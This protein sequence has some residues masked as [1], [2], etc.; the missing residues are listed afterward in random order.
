MSASVSHR[1]F[2]CLSVIALI[3]IPLLQPAL[4]QAQAT[5]P[6]APYYDPRYN[7][8]NMPKT[9]SPASEVPAISELP[10]TA[11]ELPFLLLIGVFSLVEAGVLRKRAL[12]A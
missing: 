11:G 10:A 12:R 4:T 2:L 5:E 1:I 8:E 9:A 6:N 3:L 7:N